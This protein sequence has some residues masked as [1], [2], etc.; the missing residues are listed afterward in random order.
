MG[1]LNQSGRS[2]QQQRNVSTGRSSS[3]ALQLPVLFGRLHTG[4]E[5]LLCLSRASLSN[6]RVRCE[7]FDSLLCPSLLGSWTNWWNDGGLVALAFLL[8]HRAS[9]LSICKQLDYFEFGLKNG[10]Q[11][12]GHRRVLILVGWIWGL[13]QERGDQ[14]ECHCPT[15]RESIKWDRGIQ[16]PK[17]KGKNILKSFS[18]IC[19]MICYNWSYIVNKSEIVH[20]KSKYLL[21]I[22]VF[23]F[24]HVNEVKVQSENSPKAWKLHIIGTNMP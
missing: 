19:R 6:C 17:S 3:A 2:R 18:F 13:V 21:Y 11:Y 9:L 15:N 24:R 22:H 16:F 1:Q 20:N 14:G 10:G 4:C 12:S 8:H 7:R 23:T 5:T